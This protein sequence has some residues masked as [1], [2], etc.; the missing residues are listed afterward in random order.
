MNKQVVKFL[1]FRGKNIVYLYKNGTYWIAIKPICEALNVDYLRQ[2]KNLKKDAILT[3][4][5]SKLTMQIPGDDQL[6]EYICLPE[7]Y[8]YGWIF[9]IRRSANVALHEYKLECY[10]ALYSHFHGIITRR[11]KLLKEKADITLKRRKLEYALLQ[12]SDYVELSKIKAQEISIG[13]KIK[14]VERGELQEE[15]DLFSQKDDTAQN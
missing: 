9:S 2:F 5:L 1:E 15:L 8:I 12:N 3:P 6:R 4:A 7:E 11:R 14:D 13:K 10:Q